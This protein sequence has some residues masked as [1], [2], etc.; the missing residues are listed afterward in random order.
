MEHIQTQT[1]LCVQSKPFM[2]IQWLVSYTET[3][4][5]TNKVLKYL[6]LNL[7]NLKS[8]HIIQVYEIC[9]RRKGRIVE[10]GS[11]RF[12]WRASDSMWNIKKLLVNSEYDVTYFVLHFIRGVG[13]IFM[14][15]VCNESNITLAFL[16]KCGRNCG[17]LR[18][19]YSECLLQHFALFRSFQ[20]LLLRCWR[21]PPRINKLI[22]TCSTKGLLLL[23][24]VHI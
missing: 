7:F 14:E 16:Y 2:L 3:K 8:L 18:R 13:Q 4:C 22:C 9:T 23:I 12:C 15:L 19:P 1:Y 10:I 21:L 20:L 11:L 5:K 24:C 17:C 6:N